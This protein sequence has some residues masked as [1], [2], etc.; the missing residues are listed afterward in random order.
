MPMT[1]KQMEKLLIKNGFIF[2]RQRGS[3]RMFYNPTTKRFA[4]VPMHCKDLR[5]GTEQKILKE[6]GLK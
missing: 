6:A 1:P 3:H 4:T 2:Q 5:L